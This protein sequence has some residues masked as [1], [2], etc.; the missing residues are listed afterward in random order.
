MCLAVKLRKERY[1][2]KIARPPHLLPLIIHQCLP[3][4]LPFL[5]TFSPCNVFPAIIPAMMSTP[6]FAPCDVSHDF[7]CAVKP[8]QCLTLPFPLAM[9]PTILPHVIIP[10]DV[11][12]CYPLT[13]SPTIFSFIIDPC[14]ISPLHCLPLLPPYSIAP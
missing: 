2:Y 10:H 4:L 8:L 12:H 3:P 5:S 14:N 13:K 6:P 1:V 11:L 9:P 7:A